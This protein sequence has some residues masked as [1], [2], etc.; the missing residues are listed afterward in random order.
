MEEVLKMR[1]MTP[2][3]IGLDMAQVVRLFG[4][5]QVLQEIGPE[6]AI[7]AL[8]PE[9]MI[10]ALGQALGKDRLRALLDQMEDGSDGNGQKKV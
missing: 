8:G 6:R 9:R 7:K 10:E 3:Q 1:K 5:D 4:E 2:K